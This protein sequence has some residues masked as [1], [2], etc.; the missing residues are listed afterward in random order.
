MLLI[1]LL[2]VAH[3]VIHNGNKSHIH[4]NLKTA[5]SKF[6]NILEKF[7]N[8]KKLEK[9]VYSTSKSH[10]TQNIYLRSMN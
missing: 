5:I 4:G 8:A 3:V 2:T 6:Q 10:F 9:K 7:E 1:Q